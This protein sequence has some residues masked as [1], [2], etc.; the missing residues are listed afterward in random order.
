MSFFF[1]SF[2]TPFLFLV[3]PSFSPFYPHGYLYY[4]RVGDWSFNMCRQAG[5]SRVVGTYVVMEE[6][7]R[8]ATG[9]FEELGSY[10]RESASQVWLA[11]PVPYV[12]R[13]QLSQVSNGLDV[14]GPVWDKTCGLLMLADSRSITQPN[15]SFSVLVDVCQRNILIYIY[16]HVKHLVSCEVFVLNKARWHSST[17]F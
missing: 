12:V 5:E 1:S 8:V 15:I 13:V 9:V 7:P 3:I 11:L 6:F 10:V 14:L 16:F 2:Y 4:S 17:Y